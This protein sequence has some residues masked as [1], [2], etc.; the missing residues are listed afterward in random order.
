MTH[1][2]CQP[3]NATYPPEYHQAD[4]HRYVINRRIAE[5]KDN[6]KIVESNNP[7]EE[8]N[9]FEESCE[10]NEIYNPHDRYKILTSVWPPND[11]KNY[12]AI[13]DAEDKCYKT[14]K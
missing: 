5:M 1:D 2:Q 10:V 7:R 14:L 8:V 12:W 4:S 6:F 11:I 3:P 9:F 13:T